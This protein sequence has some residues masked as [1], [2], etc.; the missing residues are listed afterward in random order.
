[1]REW[2]LARAAKKV[3]GTR[4]KAWSRA[5][6]AIWGATTKEEVKGESVKGE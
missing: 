4:S 2:A 6:I 3:A 1:M 5:A